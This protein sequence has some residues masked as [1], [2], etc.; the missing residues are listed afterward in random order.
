MWLSNKAKFPSPWN[1]F[2]GSVLV[3]E[4]APTGRPSKAQAN[5]LGQR[6]VSRAEP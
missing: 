1:R 6:I 2:L 5:G 3:C 4:E